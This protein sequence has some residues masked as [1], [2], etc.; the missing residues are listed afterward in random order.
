MGCL[1]KL[2]FLLF[3]VVH[4][5]SKSY[6]VSKGDNLTYIAK[7]FNTNIAIIKTMNRLQTSKIFIGQK[8]K[9]PSRHYRRVH[10]SSPLKKKFR[11]I[12]RYSS[13]LKNPNYG[14]SLKVK[15]N[16]TIYTVASGRIIKISYMRGHG[17]YIMV[18]HENGWYSMYSYTRMRGLRVGQKLYNGQKIGNAYKGEFVFSLS[19]KGKPINPTNLIQPSQKTKVEA[20]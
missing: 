1:Y 9:I 17:N 8:I 18:D 4:I 10:F 14:I 12:K 19:F 2:I 20:S 5:Y 3:F 15:K 6:I 13:N 7:K 16:Q 11:V